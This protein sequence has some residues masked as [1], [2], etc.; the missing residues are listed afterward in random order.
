MGFAFVG[1]STDVLVINNYGPT[2]YATLGYDT[3]VPS[4]LTFEF[5]TEEYGIGNG[6]MVNG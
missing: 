5:M 2:L 3:Y 6:V 4:F 1:Q